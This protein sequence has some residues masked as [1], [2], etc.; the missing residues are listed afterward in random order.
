M[1][2]FILL[3][4][5]LGNFALY[6]QTTQNNDYFDPSKDPVAIGNDTTIQLIVSE[7]I[8][9]K[10]VKA[11]LGQD[12]QVHKTYKKKVE[13]GVYTLVFE[14]TYLNKGTQN[15]MLRVPLTLD[16]QGQ[17][18]Y[19]SLQ[20]LICS[21]PGC[22]NCTINNGICTGCCSSQGESSGTIT[23]PLSKVQTKLD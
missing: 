16:A 13:N 21:S 6:A 5:T 20:A 2:Q 10:S 9:S 15:F 23:S 19:T 12:C 11:R 14:G 8:L 17:F 22:N 7:Y 3:F 1:K 4:F 18:Y